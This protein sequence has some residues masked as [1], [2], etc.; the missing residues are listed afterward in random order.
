[1]YKIVLI[2]L[3]FTNLLFSQTGSITGRVTDGSK[4]IPGVNIFIVGTTTGGST[5]IDGFYRISN[6]PVGDQT[7]QFSA[8]NFITI[9]EKVEIIENRTLE[10]NVDLEFKTIRIDEVKVLDDKIQEQQ[11]TRTSLIN[12]KPKSARVMPGA[13]TDVFRTLQSLPGVLAPND[14]SSQLIVRGSGPDQN[15]IIMD[16]VEIFNPYRLYGVISMFNP[17]AV[18]DINLITGG[19]P[20][21]YGDRLSAVLDVTNRQGSRSSNLTGNLNASI[22]A[23]NLVLE[24]KNPFDLPGSWI[25]NSRRTYYDLI[26]EPFVKNSGLVEDNVSFPNFYDIQTK[27]AF[28]PFDGHK[29]FINGIYSRD[30]VELVSGENRTTADSIGVVDLSKNDL[31][32]AAWHFAPNDNMLNKLTF[33]WYRNSGDANF[34]SE[35]LDPSLD[36][37]DFEDVAPDTLQPYLVN[38]GFDTDFAFRKYSIDNRF[39][40]FWGEGNEFEAGIGYDIMRTTINFSFDIDPQLKSFLSLNPNIRAVFTDLSDDIDYNRLRAHLQNRFKF[41]NLFLQ[42]GLR[43]DNYEI[44][45]KTYF[46][47]RFSASYALDDVTTLRGVWG[48]YYQSLGYEKLR[49]RQRIFDFTRAVTTSIDAEKSTH[50]V[51]SIERWLTN[52]WKVKLETYLKDFD[53]LIEPVTVPGTGYI[54]S[55]IPGEDLRLQSGWTS[56]VSTVVDSFTTIPANNSFGEAYGFEVL[57]EKKNIYGSNEINGWLSYS[58]AYANRYIDGQK[59]PFRFDQRHTV[60]LVLNY[61]IN[62]WLNIGTRFQF[63][64]GFPITEAV[65]VKPRIIFEDQNGDFIP[66]TPVVATR[67]NTNNVIYDVDFGDK[68]NRFA[69][70]KPDY[71]RLDVRLNAQADYWDLDWTFYL[72]IVNI[73]NRANVVNYDYAVDENQ[74]LTREATNMFP[75]LPTLGFNVR[76]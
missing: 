55:P 13:V 53:D 60:N 62:D 22:V 12:L 25:V 40:L 49:D 67:G 41:G 61:D 3:A 8:I 68:T 30:G 11:D 46:A 28:G 20:A 76:F 31:F 65:G 44:H 47:P 36:E 64:S 69:G 75:I 27:L 32:S 5:D 34:D 54:T 45:G 33:S 26:I 14:F 63:G 16:N 15:L 19:F 1:V 48:V 70:R 21:R 4:P 71:H 56:P 73:Y 35:L 58:L 2:L 57:V 50:Y 43:I 10:L 6:V 9:R 24:G 37:N 39:T 38:F 72:D 7:L 52:E 17:E 51:L 74:Q 66:E 29:F 59:I 23:A 42:P 18:S